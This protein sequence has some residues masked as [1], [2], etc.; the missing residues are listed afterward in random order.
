[1]ET[2]P[3]LLALLNRLHPPE[4]PTE[5]ELLA[6][7]REEEREHSIPPTLYCPQCN[8]PLTIHWHGN[9]SWI[10]KCLFCERRVIP[11]PRGRYFLQ[12]HKRY[13]TGILHPLHLVQ[14][15]NTQPVS[16]EAT[17]KY[18]ALPKFLK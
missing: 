5:A 4:Q 6:R 1:M 10:L 2:H 14:D 16:R 8:H 11:N 3:W 7:G 12:E 13:T 9:A 18:K 17:E 15:I